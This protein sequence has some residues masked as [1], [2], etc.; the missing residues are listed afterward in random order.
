MHSFVAL[1]LTNDDSSAFASNAPVSSES[2]AKQIPTN[3][4]FN[5]L[6]FLKEQLLEP[7][8]LK[9]YGKYQSM[10]CLLA[11]CTV[12]YIYSTLAIAYCWPSHI[13]GQQNTLNFICIKR[14]S[15]PIRVQIKEVCSTLFVS[16]I[17]L[18]ID[19][20]KP[21]KNDVESQSVDVPSS[22]TIALS[23]DEPDDKN[24]SQ[25]QNQGNDDKNS[26][27]TGKLNS[28]MEKK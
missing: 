12:V 3:T 24:H 6:T 7:N 22:T 18:K 8:I 26:T 15:S 23:S 13:A 9:I 25:S 2:H 10:E 28:S 16:F 11:P 5:L 19:A 27:G 14:T 17:L 4:K 20:N 21:I 1:I